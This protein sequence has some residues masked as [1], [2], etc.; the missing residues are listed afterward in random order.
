MTYAYIIAH[1]HVLFRISRA[2][3]GV[4]LRWAW[5]SISRYKVLADN[6]LTILIIHC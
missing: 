1:A 4:R 5:L 3:R 6:M 2:G